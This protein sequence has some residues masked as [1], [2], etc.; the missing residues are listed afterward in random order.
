MR[1]EREGQVCVGGICGGFFDGERCKR[2]VRGGEGPKGVFVNALYTGMVRLLSTIERIE[3][4]EVG[5]GPT[6]DAVTLTD[7]L[8]LAVQ[9]LQTCITGVPLKVTGGAIMRSELQ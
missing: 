5:L 8:P 6:G 7:S 1:R 4:R 2:Y 3:N 9:G